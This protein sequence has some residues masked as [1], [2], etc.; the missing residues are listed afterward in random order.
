MSNPRWKEIRI[1]IKSMIENTDGDERLNC[2]YG[3]VPSRRLG[4][5]LG[6]DVVAASTCTFDCIYCQLGKT[7][8]KVR[9][10]NELEFPNTNDI[11]KD[12]RAE[13]DRNEK[14]NYITVS[15]SGEPTLNPDL[16]VIADG[17]RRF[18]D[19]PLV[20]I[21]NSSLLTYDTVL[22]NAEK[23]DIVMPS[24]D[25]GDDKRFMLINRPAPGFEVDEIANAIGRLKQESKGK[26]W[27][28]VMLLKGKVTN[29]EPEAIVNIG[30]KIDQI[31]P[32]KVF[33]NTPVRPPSEPYV[34]PLDENEMNEIKL[35]LEDDLSQKVDIEIVSK[36]LPS[37]SRTS[38]MKDLS[39]A[40][41][42][43]LAVRPCTIKDISYAIGMNLSEVGKHIEM[44]LNE[45]KVS[46]R[47]IGDETYY[48]CRR[49]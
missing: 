30:R 22:E 15:G 31:L 40:I 7:I 6:I 27:L 36:Q 8:H 37:E 33:L 45:G 3:P 11:L 12:L 23:F 38:G 9:N 13:L 34:T 32:D 17:I 18:T 42:G 41:L 26:V 48:A 10:W 35:A 25:A 46:M 16:G 5:S 1:G 29:A 14:P 43:L 47:V 19:L 21:T 4:I 49:R 44:L 20:L 2:V 28:E 24:L 39:S